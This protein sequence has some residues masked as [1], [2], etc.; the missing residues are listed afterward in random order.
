MCLFLMKLQ[1]RYVADGPLLR[2][3][4][5]DFPTPI[6]ASESLPHS[7]PETQLN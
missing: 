2:K 6:P 4:Y 1:D 3:N 7:R 5:D